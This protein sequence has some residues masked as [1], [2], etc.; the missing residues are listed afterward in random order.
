MT[1]IISGVALMP[2]RYMT[3]GGEYIEIRPID[4]VNASAGLTGKP[5][6]TDHIDNKVDDTK[7]WVYE[8]VPLSDGKAGVYYQAIVDDFETEGHI[9]RIRGM[10]QIPN[11]SMWMEPDVDTI[12][13]E[14]LADGS[15]VLHADKWSIRHL[16]LVN[17]GRCSDE[18]GCGVLDYR[19]INSDHPVYKKTCPYSDK[20]D[21]LTEEPTKDEKT[22]KELTDVVLKLQSEID[23]LKSEN[24]SMKQELEDKK[25]VLSEF[26]QEK[27]D[28]E[29]KE[30]DDLKALI[31]KEDS[32]A[33]IDGV[34]DAASLKVILS[35]Y[36]TA[37]TR[38]T[39]VDDDEGNKSDATLRLEKARQARKA[40]MY[41]VKA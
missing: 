1:Q 36:R 5:F 23:G 11:I 40:K 9:E 30:V 33:D 13:R 17:K 29:K 25:L 21:N 19:V 3:E 14:T 4:V 41:S 10:G 28:A 22:V 34:D 8:G 20:G 15:V 7:G 32:E 38:S 37:Q 39:E 26:E 35:A 6:V 2:D 16:S 12:T 27:T 31:L 18:D 24:E